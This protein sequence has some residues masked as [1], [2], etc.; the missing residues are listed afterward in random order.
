MDHR[1]N[2]SLVIVLAVLL[3][4]AGC[5]SPQQQ[6]STPTLTTFPTTEATIPPTPKPIITAS[7][8]PGPVDTLPPQWPLSVTV[9]KSGLYSR[10]IITHFDGGK[11]LM[12]TTRMDVRVT[13]PDGTVLTDGIAKPS[14]G[15]TVEILGSDGSDRVEVMVTMANGGIYKIIDQQ[16]A[17][18]GR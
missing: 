11:G 8:I 4:I 7:N 15:D 1:I 14:M 16:M 17:F 3:T 6:V 18:K 5:S 13:Y 12:Y 9:E 10:T 2:L